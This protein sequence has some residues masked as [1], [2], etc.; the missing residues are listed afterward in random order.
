MSVVI[1]IVVAVVALWAAI[2]AVRAISSAHLNRAL[3]ADAP[4][5]DDVAAVMSVAPAAAPPARAA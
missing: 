2:A 1:P 4:T 5:Q 3:R